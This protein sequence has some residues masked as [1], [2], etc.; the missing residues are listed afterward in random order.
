VVHFKRLVID[1]YSGRPALLR[2]YIAFPQE[3][4]FRLKNGSDKKFTLTSVL[5]H[6]GNESMGHYYT[7]RK[8]AKDTDR[9]FY[10]SD[11]SN[12]CSRYRCGAV[13]L[14]LRL[15]PIRLHDVLRELTCL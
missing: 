15:P 12:V 7:F 13:Q 2:K 1:P 10:A 3:L 9:W 4:S 11:R 14:A 5:S 8:E 6:S